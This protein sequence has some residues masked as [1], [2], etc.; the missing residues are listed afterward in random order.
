MYLNRSDAEGGA[1]RAATN[2]L[3]SI[4]RE[5]ISAN[6][7]VQRKS[8][9]HPAV[10]GLPEFPG[11]ALGSARR[12]LETIFSGQCLAKNK[13]LFSPALLPDRLRGVISRSKADLVHLHWTA[14]MMRLETLAQT[15]RPIVW[16]L[17]DSWPFTGGCFLPGACERYRD[18]C[19]MCPVLSS[20][21]ED[22]L[23]RRTW[24][25]KH[26]AWRNLNL[27]LIAP[28]HWMGE[29]ARSSALFQNRRVEI[30]P[31]G[32]DIS[33]FTPV[34][35]KTARHQFGLP[36]GKRLILFGAKSAVRDRNKGFHLLLKALQAAEV[37]DMELVVIGAGPGDRPSGLAV[38]S[39]FLGW[40]TDD[41]QLAQLYSAV[42]AFALPSLQENLPYTVME[43]MACGTPCVAFCQGGVP[44]LIDHRNNGYLARAFD[45]KDF[46][47]GL[48]YI[49]TDPAQRREMGAL[50]RHK[51]VT[52]FAID[53]VATR[54]FQL[55]R[56][57][58]K[59]KP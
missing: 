14:R 1:A 30:I 56:N 34:D 43:A 18:A 16:T 29:R 22:D 44:D 54:H 15:M 7:H 26:E 3:N 39:H 11:K 59:K 42:D 9:S 53:R 40:Q 51:I 50:A 10:S 12:I 24:Q 2:L 31:N 8:S 48:R 46:G 5:G 58:L 37:N 25:R 28:S 45:P 55:Y 27:T 6:L 21:R 47:H 20:H 19:G 38:N 41:S 52:E 4:T 23:S 35:P 17:H 33:R 13:G 36:Q 57:L 32:I 49:L